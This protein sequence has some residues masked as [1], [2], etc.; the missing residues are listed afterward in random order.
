M[1]DFE[2]L[3]NTLSKSTYG[4]HGFDLPV[5]MLENSMH[6][7]IV[8]NVNDKILAI[9]KENPYSPVISFK[10]S[11]GSRIIIETY[12]YDYNENKRN[13][14]FGLYG[15]DIYVN[16]ENHYGNKCIILSCV[17]RGK[18][19]IRNIRLLNAD[20]DTDAYL[21]I[22]VAMSNIKI[23]VLGHVYDTKSVS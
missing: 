8:K 2:N 18:G 6:R 10:A 7:R 20:Y 23:G 22:K 16:H 9:V 11:D 19:H 21:D 4:S 15:V 5:A 17:Q 3:T 13:S 1:K 12:I 14:P